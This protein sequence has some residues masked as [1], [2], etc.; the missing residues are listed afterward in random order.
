MV[1][2]CS[3]R[4]SWVPNWY[5]V[6]VSWSTS[7]RRQGASTLRYLLIWLAEWAEPFWWSWRW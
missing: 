2:T 7:T 3:A 4:Y 6:S 1:V 5:I